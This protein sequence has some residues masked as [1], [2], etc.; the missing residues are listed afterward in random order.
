MKEEMLALLIRYIIFIAV[1]TLVLFGIFAW[2]AQADEIIPRRDL[3]EPIGKVE[4]SEGDDETIEVTLYELKNMNATADHYDEVIEY[5][6]EDIIPFYNDLAGMYE[7]ALASGE[8]SLE[9]G[10]DVID[11]NMKLQEDLSFWRSFG[12]GAIGAIGGL[13]LFDTVIQ[14]YVESIQ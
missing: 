7:R 9:I 3:I 5:V 11:E 6:N 14:P 10:Y 2:P 4:W 8:K 1:G 13:V 12:L